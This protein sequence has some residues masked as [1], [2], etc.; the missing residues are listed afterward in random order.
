VPPPVAA[1]A[2]L[3]WQLLT[4]ELETRARWAAHCARTVQRAQR[5]K[6]ANTEPLVRPTPEREG[7]ETAAVY[8]TFVLP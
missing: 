7:T 3:R 4:D 2:S 5:E 1:V 8:P 6:A